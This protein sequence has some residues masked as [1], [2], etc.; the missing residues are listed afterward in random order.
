MNAIRQV[1]QHYKKLSLL[2]MSGAFFL[3]AIG[4]GLAFLA[5]LCELIC[6]RIKQHYF[7]ANDDGRN[8]KN[9]FQTKPSLVLGVTEAAAVA[10]SVVLINPPTA[11]TAKSGDDKENTSAAKMEMLV[12]VDLEEWSPIVVYASNTQTIEIQPLTTAA[13]NVI[14]SNLE[15]NNPSP[16]RQVDV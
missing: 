10:I 7:D 15:V 4:H 16:I 9:N 8:Q 11:P 2:S 3:L 14:K 5:F 1:D 6:K 13:D 12:T